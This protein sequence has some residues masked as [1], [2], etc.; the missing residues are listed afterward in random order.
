MTTDFLIFGLLLVLVAL[1]F[2]LRPLLQARQSFTIIVFLIIALPGITWLV[3]SNIGTP[4]AM[5]PQVQRSQS[6]DAPQTM[7][8]AIAMLRAELQENPDN[9]EGWM[10]L[11]RTL[12]TMNKPGEAV[13]VYRKVL[14]MAPDEPYVKME[15]G[16]AILR[17]TDPAKE[18]GF[19]AETKTLLE[20]AYAADPQLQ[21]AQWLLGI[22]AASEGNHQRALELWEDLLPKIDPDSNIVATLT[23]QIN[24]SRS[25][26]GIAPLDTATH[27]LKI[28][29]KLADTIAAVV[30]P[31]AVVFVFLKIPDQAG[32]PLAVKRLPATQL[33]LELELTDA[34]ILQ[35]GKSLQ[36]Y[37]QLLLSAKLSSRGTA[38]AGTDDMY[39]EAIT[40]NPTEK[41]AIKLILKPKEN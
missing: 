41:Q 24:Q 39:A 1:A 37:P 21:K 34:D 13:Q 6:A 31:Q 11:G 12:L 40:I 22:A 15:L 2:I 26:L 28:S 38:D 23:Q 9:I 20:E 27:S 35:P 18:Q 8:E 30:N 14:S 17:A 16:N 5:Q 32:M 10:L 29:V 25:A 7:E 33:P 19:P 36:D 3:Y 4:E